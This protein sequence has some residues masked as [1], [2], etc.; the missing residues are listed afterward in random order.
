VKVTGTKASESPATESRQDW[1]STALVKLQDGKWLLEDVRF[2][3]VETGPPPT[4]RPIAKSEEAAEPVDT[5][6]P[7]PPSTEP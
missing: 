2:Y 1:H 6:D 5:P 3:V 7:G 4:A